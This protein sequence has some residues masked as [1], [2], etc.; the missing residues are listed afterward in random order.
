MFGHENYFAWLKIRTWVVTQSSEMFFVWFDAGGFIFGF[1][2]ISFFERLIE[3]DPKLRGWE[4]DVLYN[5][6][7]NVERRSTLSSG[8]RSSEV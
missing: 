3:F 2:K 4:K 1:Q 7:A 5:D 6:P 8:L